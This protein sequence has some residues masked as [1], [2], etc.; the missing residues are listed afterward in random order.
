MS[1]NATRASDT[2]HAIPSASTGP[3]LQSNSEPGLRRVSIAT[4]YVILHL[5]SPFAPVMAPVDWDEARPSSQ[6]PRRGILSS[7]QTKVIVAWF[8]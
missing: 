8:R 5:I 7:A 3:K 2:S 4:D 1:A 6:T